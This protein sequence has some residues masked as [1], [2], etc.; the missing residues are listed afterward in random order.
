VILNQKISN[1]PGAIF[2][3]EVTR[4]DFN[5]AEDIAATA[6]QPAAIPSR[7]EAGRALQPA[8]VSTHRE[9][10]MINPYSID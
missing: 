3:E 8:D 5:S 9:P 10:E 6:L 2:F 7:P 1:F 4:E